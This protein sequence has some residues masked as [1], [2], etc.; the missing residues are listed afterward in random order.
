MHTPSSLLSL[1]ALACLAAGPS[2]A[3]SPPASSSALQS[4]AQADEIVVTAQRSGIPVW[5]VTGPRTTV[6]LVGSIGSVA[7]GTRWDPVPL[8]AALTRADRVMFPEAMAFGGGLGTVVS[9][10]GKWRKQSTLPK[11]ETLQAM[12]T[13]AQWARLVALR[14]KG[15]LKP[16][17]ERKHP[18]HLA[19]GL[20]R[21]VRD[22][23]KLSPGA[24]AYVRTFLRKNKTKR[25]PLQQGSAKELMAELFGS[26][27]RAHVPCLM[28]AVQLAEQG[29]GGVR[30]RSSALTVRSNAWAARRVPDV[31]A[32]G[33]GKLTTSCWPQGGRLVREN[34][35]RLMPAVR[36]LLAKPQVTL[37]VMSLDSLAE[38]GGVLDD[39][40]AAG[41]DV[42]GPRWKS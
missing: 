32:T 6:V 38:R 3:Q 36:S 8:D 35:A 7:P 11:G 39:L 28:E 27:P 33:T 13:P 37:A 4:S 5:R 40:V 23:R 24:D 26:A 1:V 17:F 12:T 22:K 18:F 29:A 15:V 34:D 9:A 25:V 14:D 10:L 19:M 21:S 31:L 41:F 2:A 20:T 30:A 16:G 42:R